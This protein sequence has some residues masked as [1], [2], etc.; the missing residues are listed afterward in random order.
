MKKA[1]IITAV[2]AGIGGTLWYLY[3]QVRLLKEYCMEFA[4]YKIIGASA[5]AVGMEIYLNILNKSNLDVTVT[6]YDIDVFLDNRFVAKIQDIAH[7]LIRSEAKSRLVLPVNFAPKDLFKGIKVFQFIKNIAFQ[8]ENI[9]IKLSG[10]LSVKGGNLVTLKNLPV[11][12]TATLRELQQGG[13]P[14][15]Y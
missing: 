5:K 14:C 3:N 10:T 12:Y 9:V 13:E 6:G 7:Q 4:G 15:Y 8:P 2:L 11:D 1:L